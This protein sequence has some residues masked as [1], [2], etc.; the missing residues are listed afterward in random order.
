MDAWPIL[1]LECY[2]GHVLPRKAMGSIITYH[3]CNY[4]WVWEGTAV[5]PGAASLGRPEGEPEGGSYIPT[6]K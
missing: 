1:V 4:Q 5:H 2:A 3:G 6:T